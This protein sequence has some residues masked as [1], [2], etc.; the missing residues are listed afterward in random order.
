MIATC[1]SVA[2]SL[3]GVL[4]LALLTPS[5]GE[6][7]LSFGAYEFFWLAMFGVMMSGS[8]AGSDPVKGWLMGFAGLFLTMV[9]QDGMHAHDRFTFGYGDLSGGLSLIPA[10][11]GAFGFSEILT[12]LSEPAKKAIV[13]KP[14]E[15]PRDVDPRLGLYKTFHAIWSTANIEEGEDP[16]QSL[17]G[18]EGI[19]QARLSR[20]TPLS[21]QA[22]LLT[23]L[24][25]FS[26]DDT[27]YLIGASAADVDS[28]VAEA[29]EEIERQTLADVKGVIVEDIGRE[30][31]GIVSLVI[32]GH[33]AGAVKQA[34]AGHKINVSVSGASSTLLDMNARKLSQ[35][36]RASVHY[37]NTQDEIG[38]FAEAVGR[39]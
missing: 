38:R 20:I 35:V 36:V 8:I 29:L 17:T 13:A 14:D 10:L 3:F 6:V 39:L 18:A 2:G 12:V 28:L 31:C 37:Y 5:L 32:E 7:A 22:L 9:G 24:E 27:A 16:S 15:F 30:K 11:I 4:C 21:R 19:A 34:L 23:S 33:E 25:G 26:S 1:G